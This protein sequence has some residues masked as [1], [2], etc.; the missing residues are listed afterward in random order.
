MITKLLCFIV[1]Y[2]FSGFVIAA[3]FKTI[4]K[5]HKDVI[6]S[7][8]ILILGFGLG[9]ITISLILYFLFLFFPN[10]ANLFYIF[11][12]SI[13]FLLMLFIGR[14]NVL[15]GREFL[16]W[17]KGIKNMEKDVILIV[18]FVSVVMSYIFIQGI[19]FPVVSHDGPVYGYYGK[20]LYQEKNLDNYPMRKPDKKTGA[21]LGVAHPPGFPLIYTWFYLL[22]GNTKSD[23]LARTVSPMYAL[24]LIILLW[25]IL[26]T[27]KNKYCAAF[28]VLLLALTPLFIQQSYDNSIDPI[29]IYFIFL[30]FILL[31]KF[32]ASDLFV[33]MLFTAIAA[34]FALYIHAAGILVLLVIAITYLLLSKKN[35]RRRIVSAA[36]I[37]I[38]AITLGGVQYGI[39]SIKS[40]TGSIFGSSSSF[41]FFSA[42]TFKLISYAK[43]TLI[44]RGQFGKI[45]LGG[46]P[47]S[48]THG[49]LQVFSRIELFG[50]SYYIFLFALFYWI[51]YICKKRMDVVLLLGAI[52]FAIPVIYKYWVNGRYIFTIHPMIIY[53]GGLVL[54]T[55]YN[56]LK[57]RKLQK[58][59]WIIMFFIFLVM[60][61]LFF[62]PD[63]IASRKLGSIKKISRYMFSNKKEQAYMIHPIFEAI[64]YINIKTAKDSTVLVFRAPEYFYNSKRKGIYYRDP[65]LKKFYRIHN[66]N[67]AYEYL[68]NL[69]VDYIIINSFYEQLSVFKNSEFKNILEDKELCD[70]VFEKKGTKVYQLKA[71]KEINY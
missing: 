28:G 16:K 41:A 46:I 30:S 4:L 69:D 54:G 57:E 43:P 24:Y 62:A 51:R 42:E 15:K 68:R 39:N 1:T 19:C 58:K 17:L 67:E 55:I 13:I 40:T 71:M 20:Y 5:K 44:A 59:F 10:K 35:I 33:I 22:Q 34:G 27:R 49:R 61:T 25:I 6:S 29:R 45:G 64:E 9:P 50:L 63:S 14:K 8:E 32:I 26:R 52:L 12:V 70:V 53:F 66:T 65:I 48:I 2:L 3:F 38:I 7:A 36:L 23:I 60:T 18:A 21:Y 31:A 56:R 37:G 11:I 47:R